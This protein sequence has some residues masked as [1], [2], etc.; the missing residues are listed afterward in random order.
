M[1]GGREPDPPAQLRP[2]GSPAVQAKN[3]EPVVAKQ[4]AKD[5]YLE[6]FFSEAAS[7]ARSGKSVYIRPEYHER[8]TR[9]VQVIG[10]DRISLYSYLDNVL[11]H[12]FGEFSAE[13]TRNFNES[14]KPIL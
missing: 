12:H 8:L 6:L 1:A 11:S 9:I 14:Y 4:Q 10:G 2:A 13:I 5:T 3:P 7:N